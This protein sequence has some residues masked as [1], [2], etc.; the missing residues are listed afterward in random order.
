MVSGL[1]IGG[2]L[3]NWSAIGW[4]VVSGSIDGGFNKTA[5]LLLNAHIFLIS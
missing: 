3:G 4:S 5:F 2:S 1:M